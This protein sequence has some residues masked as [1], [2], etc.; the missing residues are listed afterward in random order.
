LESLLE[1][2]AGAHPIFFTDPDAGQIARYQLEQ[3]GLLYRL[4]AAAAS[5]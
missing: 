2:N 4:Q 5:P 1:A 3:Q